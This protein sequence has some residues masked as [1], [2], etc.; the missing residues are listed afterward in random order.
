M[1][2]VGVLLVRFARNQKEIG[3]CVEQ[4]PRVIYGELQNGIY[5]TGQ[6][7]DRGMGVGLGH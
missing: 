3:M 4:I 7:C 1:L 5:G 2:I 6:W